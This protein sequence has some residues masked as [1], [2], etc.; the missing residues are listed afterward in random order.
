MNHWKSPLRSK[1]RSLLFLLTFLQNHKLHDPYTT[2]MQTSGFISQWI[3]RRKKVFMPL[4]LMW[5]FVRLVVGVLTLLPTILSV[6]TRHNV[7]TCGFQLEIPETLRFLILS[8]LVIIT[9]VA[10]IYDLICFNLVELTRIG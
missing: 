4:I 7:R 1:T 10:M 9:T 3:A 2:E 5:L 6:D 8:L